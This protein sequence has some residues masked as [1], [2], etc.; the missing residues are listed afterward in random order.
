VDEHTTHLLG[1]D[2]IS[3]R[4]LQAAAVTADVGLAHMRVAAAAPSQTGT[5][6]F[7][8]SHENLLSRIFW[9]GSPQEAETSTATP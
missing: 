8:A 1:Q 6:I 4:S 9:F 2:L 7:A 5:T 3:D